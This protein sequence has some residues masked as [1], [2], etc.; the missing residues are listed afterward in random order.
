MESSNNKGYSLNA[1]KLSLTN[2]EAQK[3][4]QKNSE[5]SDVSATIDVLIQSEA[6]ENMSSGPINGKCMC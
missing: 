4:V 2:D 1:E 5:K 3:E 6:P